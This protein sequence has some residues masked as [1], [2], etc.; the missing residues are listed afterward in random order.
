VTVTSTR[1]ALTCAA[2]VLK[3]IRRNDNGAVLVEFAFVVIPFIALILA[4][5]YTSLIYFSTQALETAVQTS[6]R[7][8]VT[9]TTQIAGTSQSA[10]KTQVC[11]NIPKYMDCS[12][13]YVDVRRA[14]TFASLDL[15]AP[16]VTVNASGNVTNSGS[17]ETI[18]KSEMGMV[19]IVYVWE[20]GSGPLG[21]DL[22]T[23][24]NGKRLLFAT[25]VFRAEPYGG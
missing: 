16:N 6:A 14:T 24:S 15:S 22:S 3:R 12:K 8:I 1:R 20:A 10:Y 25:S 9:G 18:G 19:R 4:S 11:N 5:L 13:L 2:S 7:S 17:Y 23:T 21:L